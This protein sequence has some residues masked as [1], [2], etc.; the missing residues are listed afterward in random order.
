MDRKADPMMGYGWSGYRVQAWLRKNIKEPRRCRMTELVEEIGVSRSVI[1]KAIDELVA[2]KGISAGFEY[3]G[4]QV[5]WR[6]APR[7]R[8]V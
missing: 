4:K 5:Y 2:S 6:L 7:E 3:E 8:N 1:Y